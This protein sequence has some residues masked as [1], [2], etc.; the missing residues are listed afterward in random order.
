MS[1]SVEELTQTLSQLSLPESLPTSSIEDLYETVCESDTLEETSLSQSK[2]SN[3]DISLLRYQAD[4]IPHFDGNAR[5]LQRFICS[6]E[7]FLINFQNANDPT[8]AINI[9]LLDTIL[10]K[11]RGRAADLIGS[12][13]ELKTWQQIKNALNVTFSDQRGIDCLIQD[14]ISIKPL[15]NES[16]INFGM[17]IQDARSLLFAKL[18]SLIVN[19]NEKLIKIAHYDDFALKTF[20]AGLPYHMQLVVRLKNPENL[21]QALA[22]TTEEENFIYFSNGRTNNSHNLNFKNNIPPITIPKPQPFTPSRPTNFQPNFNHVKPPTMFNRPLFQ[23]PNNSLFRNPQ[24]SF[25]SNQNIFQQRPFQM[26]PPQPFQNFRNPIAQPSF[27]P[28][29]NVNYNPFKAQSQQFKPQSSVMRTQTRPNNN[30]DKVTPMDTRSGNTV[31]YNPPKPKYTFEELYAQQISDYP[32]TS[33]KT[34]QNFISPNEFD[35]TSQINSENTEIYNN[36]E[37][38]PDVSNLDYNEPYYDPQNDYYYPGEQPEYPSVIEPQEN[39]SQI[40][41]TKDQT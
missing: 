40:Q 21:E 39:F 19:E 4:N 14:L 11:L 15:K 26:R 12:R 13:S 20:L 28:P 41:Q 6:C 2:M 16:P 35:P 23:P 1:D 24:P 5:L 34:P 27:R 18:S 29:Q 7:N 36:S 25:Q 22:Y 32:F 33:E 38:F 8:D 31:L 37:Y 10:G 9:I 30:L 3:K 17:R